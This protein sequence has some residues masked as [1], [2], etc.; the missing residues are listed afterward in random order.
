MTGWTALV[1]LKKAGLRKSRLGDRLSVADRD[2]LSDA[3]ALHVIQTLLAVPVVSSVVLLSEEAPATAGV[4]WLADGGG[5]LNAE[6]DA[7][8][9]VLDNGPL[10]ILPADLPW[11]QRD[12]VEALIAAAAGGHAIAPDRRER[13]TNGLALAAPRGFPFAFGEGSFRRHLFA[14]GEG[15]AIVRRRGL[16]FDIDTL[17]DL[18]A[19]LAQGFAIDAH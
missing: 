13:G 5:G 16:A 12:D 17:A 15:A 6:L 18:D 11:L 10:V 8:A 1:P 4:L 14:V 3:L 7:A 19:A 9:A 2:G